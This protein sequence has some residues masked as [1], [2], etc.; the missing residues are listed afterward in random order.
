M[1]LKQSGSHSNLI[2]STTEQ[3][4]RA[5]PFCLEGQ[6]DQAKEKVLYDASVN[7]HVFTVTVLLH[8]S[9]LSAGHEMLRPHALGSPVVAVWLSWLPAS[10]FLF[11]HTD[12]L[13]RGGEGWRA[14]LVKRRRLSS[15]A[16]KMQLGI[17]VSEKGVCL[18]C[19]SEEHV[20]A[21]AD[22]AS[23]GAAD[24]QPSWR[25]LTTWYCCSLEESSHHSTKHFLWIS[26]FQD[27]RILVPLLSNAWFVRYYPT[28]WLA[29]VPLDDFNTWAELVQ[30]LKH[31]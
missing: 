9:T 31:G 3:K 13:I 1:S 15:R 6:E 26:R 16:G 20:R 28:W 18:N 22:G 14:P 30:L 29:D 10:L 2:K 23:L 17:K 8:C 7:C 19:T 11:L 21:E 4:R 5:E 24:I 27:E 12:R 25:S